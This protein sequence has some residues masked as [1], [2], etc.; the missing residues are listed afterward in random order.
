[1]SVTLPDRLSI[2]PGSPF[3]NEDILQNEI[4][5]RFNGKEK[6]NVVEYCLS[7]GWI[8]VEAGAAR[9]RK[10]KPMLLTLKGSVEAFVK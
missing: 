10:G 8:K 7:E 6:T 9:D 5:I 2:D 1:M 4:G 3:Y